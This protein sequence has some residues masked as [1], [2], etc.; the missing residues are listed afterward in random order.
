[1]PALERLDLIE[2]WLSEMR[3]DVMEVEG[4]GHLAPMLQI[5]FLAFR[6]GRGWQNYARLRR[7]RLPEVYE[8]SILPGA[9][10]DSDGYEQWRAEVLRTLPEDARHRFLVMFAAAS[11]LDSSSI[12]G[13]LK[14]LAEGGEF[15]FKNIW[16]LVDP[17]QIEGHS[18][19]QSSL[20]SLS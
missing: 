16:A 14:M 5:D 1:M 8:P 13:H 19:K 18:L 9:K 6:E 2:E 20:E 17:M 10:E 3:F 7:A 12:F 11:G 15:L 4:Y